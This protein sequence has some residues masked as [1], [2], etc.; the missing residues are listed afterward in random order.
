MGETRCS[1]NPQGFFVAKNQTASSGSV[2][3]FL[4]PISDFSSVV[5]DKVWCPVR[6]LKWYLDKTKAHRKDDQLF[7]ITREP[8]SPASKE[9]ISRWIVEAIQSAGRDALFSVEKPRAHDT[10]S[11]ST[12]WALFQG[13]ALEDILRAAF[14]RSPNS[15]I[16]FYL[17]DIPAS[18][19]RFAAS[20]LLGAASAV[21][22][23]R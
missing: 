8:F 12:S 23:S 1:S 9:S 6:A 13:S 14:W 17:R 15:F 22:S 21:S 2:E 5:T 18:E 7:L 11:V 10:R 16:S 19:A 20:S 3:I 4:S